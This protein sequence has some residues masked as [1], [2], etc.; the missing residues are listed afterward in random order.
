M[1]EPILL[2][3][4]YDSFTH[5]LLHLAE[6]HYEG[7]IHLIAND[8]ERLAEAIA[9][10]NIIILS[11]GPGLPHE[12]GKLMEVMPAVLAK[13]KVLG[14][15]LGHQ[16]IASYYGAQLFQDKQVYHGISS[17]MHLTDHKD[18]LY[19]GI[20]PLFDV[21]RYHSWMVSEKNL[22]SQIEIT[23]KDSAGNIMSY[24]IKERN[25]RGIQYHPESILCAY[26]DAIMKNWLN[27]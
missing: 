7:K 4:N 19:E 13:K 9:K 23:G 24:R 1:N 14:V 5:N 21:A 25:I 10:H 20:P 11:P 15:C 22:P 27:L 6:K 16:A 8:N 2:I 3:D 26:S 18:S 17:P 12:A